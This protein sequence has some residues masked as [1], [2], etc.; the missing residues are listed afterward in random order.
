[1][2][3]LRTLIEEAACLVALGLFFAT[4]FLWCDIISHGIH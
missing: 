1:M 3:L 4:I 2:N